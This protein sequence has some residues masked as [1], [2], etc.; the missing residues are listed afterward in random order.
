MEYADHLSS[1]VKPIG[2]GATVQ[3]VVKQAQAPVSQT[4]KLQGY[5]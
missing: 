5:C 1:W 2:R 3:A 4:K